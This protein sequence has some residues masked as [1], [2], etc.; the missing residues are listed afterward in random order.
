M[1]TSCS[2]QAIYDINRLKEMHMLLT[3]NSMNFYDII[4]IMIRK[5]EAQ[6]KYCRFNTIRSANSD[7]ELRFLGYH[8]D[9]FVN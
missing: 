4:D 3:T 5:P 6:K 9:Q 2:R 7:P 8:S 1:I